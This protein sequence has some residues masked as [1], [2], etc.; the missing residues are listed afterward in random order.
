MEVAEVGAARVRA[1]QKGTAG[2]SK[3]RSRGSWSGSYRSMCSRRISSW[4]RGS[5]SK[6]RTRR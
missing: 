1:A 5:W 4:S 6:N 3:I 2:V